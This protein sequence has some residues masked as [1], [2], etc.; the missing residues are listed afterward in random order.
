MPPIPLIQADWPAPPNVHAVVSTRQDGVSQAPWESLNLGMHVNDNPDAVRNNRQRL[1]ATL[2]TIAPV[3][4][5]PWLNQVHGIK[6][7][8]A[9]KNSATSSEQTIT[10]DATTT[11]EKNLACVVMTADC[12]PVFFCN[13]EGTRVAVAHAGWRG[14]CD[15]ILEETLKT[16]TDPAQVIA[17]LGPAIGPEKFEVGEEV[18]QAFMAHQIEAAEAFRPRHNQG[19]W[20][21]DI[22]TLA[23]QRLGKAGIASVHGGSF[24]THT[25]SER[26][27]SYRRDGETGRMASVIW[28]A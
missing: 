7:V 28:L 6:V 11:T 10:A 23:R 14:L 17:W 12:L 26:F 19:K 15:G 25:D 8:E 18:R 9:E 21:A 1:I 3:E 24:C 13:K 4:E 2:Q 16:F 22:Y 27:F 5:G 20:L